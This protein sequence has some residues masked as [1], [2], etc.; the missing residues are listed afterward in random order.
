MTDH[1][2]FRCVVPVAAVDCSRLHV[3]RAPSP[4][5]PECGPQRAL[6]LRGRLHKR[7][8]HQ[9]RAPADQFRSLLTARK[10]VLSH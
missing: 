6:P 9:D 5:A 1:R 2:G 8:R 4:A 3:S 10:G 7:R